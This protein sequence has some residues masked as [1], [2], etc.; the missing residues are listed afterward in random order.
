MKII[1]CF[2]FYNEYDMLRLR[3]EYLCDVVDYFLISESNI[4]FSG[5]PKPYNLDFIWDQI[6]S[7]IRDKIIRIKYEPDV[8]GLDFSTKEY[9]I[10]NDFW[11]IERGQRECISRY[12]SNFNLD[13][14]VMISDLDEV[15]DKTKIPSS[16]LFVA[17][18]KLFYYD[19]SN[20]TNVIWPGTIFTDV[21]YVL[22]N[23]FDSLRQNRYNLPIIS[24]CGWHFSYFGDVNFIK[25]KITMFAHQENN[26]DEFV[27]ENNILNSI[28]QKKDLYGRDIIFTEYDINLYPTEIK[29][30]MWDTKNDNTNLY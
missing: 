14:R 15:P 19:F 28:N 24:D 6:P 13:D 16:G 5:K 3:T 9:H 25:N 7:K 8:T 22:S 26:R 10:D 18:T 30:L 27:N 12:L 21:K 20:F 4:T 17:Q 2:L 11:K 23:G 1:D 29:N